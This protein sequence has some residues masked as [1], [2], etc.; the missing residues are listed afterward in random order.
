MA[1]KLVIFATHGAENPDKATL[2]FVVGNAALAMDV[3]VTVIL[4][5]EGVLLATKGTYD[6]IF[7]PGFD[8]LKKL[9]DSFIEFGG[10]IFM[11]VP[12]LEARKITSDM[13][14]EKVQLVKAGRVVQEVLEA[15]AVLNY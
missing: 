12:C 15:K 6:H 10:N 2:P 14:L 9:V 13:L 4:Q 7:C 5:G 1:E 3:Q 8:P 11:C